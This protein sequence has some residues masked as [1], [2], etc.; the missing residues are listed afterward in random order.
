[1]DDGHLTREDLAGIR[2]AARP[3]LPKGKVLRKRSLL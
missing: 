3:M 1:M 2:K